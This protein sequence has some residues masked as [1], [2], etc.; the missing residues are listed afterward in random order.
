M[1]S[2]ERAARQRRI[3]AG[4]SGLRERM[5]EISAVKRE[6]RVERLRDEPESELPP[7]GWIRTRVGLRRAWPK[8]APDG[9]L[10]PR[11]NDNA[12]DGPE[13]RERTV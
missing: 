9:P 12:G 10:E 8:S 7:D 1:T 2:D 5:A 13:R 11:T 4:Q 3:A 6:Q